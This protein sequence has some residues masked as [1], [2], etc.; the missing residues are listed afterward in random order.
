MKNKDTVIENLKKKMKHNL[1]K[2]LA[3]CDSLPPYLK[4]VEIIEKSQK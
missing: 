2:A 1:P 3:L 4:G